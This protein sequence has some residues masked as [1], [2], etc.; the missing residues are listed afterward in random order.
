M[1][2]ARVRL[3]FRR[4]SDD[5]GRRNC[6]SSAYLLYSPRSK[7]G[8]NNAAR[9]TSLPSRMADLTAVGTISTSGK[10]SEV[11][12]CRPKAREQSVNTGAHRDETPVDCSSL[13]IAVVNV[14]AVGRSTLEVE[15]EGMVCG[16]IG[17]VM[18]AELR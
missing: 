13:S 3:R 12:P 18:D 11:N 16:I 6:E 8:I 10:S 4:G 17:V 15:V 7:F 1:N 2:S 9:L 14:N 5:S